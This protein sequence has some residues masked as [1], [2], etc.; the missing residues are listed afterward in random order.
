VAPAL[1]ALGARI[2]IR[3][4][5]PVVQTI[6]TNVPGPDFPL[7][8]L[9]RRIED[10]FPYVPLTGGIQLSTAVF[11]YNGRLTFGVSADFDGQP[12]VEVF[13]EG[14]RAGF[15]ELLDAPSG[16]PGSPDGPEN[17]SGSGSATTPVK[18]A[19]RRAR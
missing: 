15:A 3:M 2:P 14:I 1:L 12:D 4:F 18:A 9:G 7:Y 16:S 17:D 10:L 5:N 6:T 19:G 8:V 11:S 13:A